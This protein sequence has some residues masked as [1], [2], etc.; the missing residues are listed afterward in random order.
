VTWR[1]VTETCG[2]GE[3]GFSSVRA[4]KNGEQR[5]VRKL[6]FFTLSKS[7]ADRKIWYLPTRAEQSV[8]SLPW[9]PQ[10]LTASSLFFKTAD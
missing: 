3:R 7:I 8:D 4:S 6:Q 10:I 2:W 9:K 1:V 5:I